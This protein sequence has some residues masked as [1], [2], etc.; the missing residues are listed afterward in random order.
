MALEAGTMAPYPIAVAL[1]RP[2][3]ATSDSVPK[4]VLAL[5]VAL[6]ESAILP[7]ATLFALVVFFVKASEP[8]ALFVPLVVL[9]ANADSTIHVLFLPKVLTFNESQPHSE[10]PDLFVLTNIDV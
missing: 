9:S 8:I 5:P 4:A 2:S 1:P 10:F 7:P 3:D 6:L